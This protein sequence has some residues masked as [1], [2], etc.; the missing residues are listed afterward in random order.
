[1][2]TNIQTQ[3]DIVKLLHLDSYNFQGDG[4]FSR[5]NMLN[6]NTVLSISQERLDAGKFKNLKH[7]LGFPFSVQIFCFIL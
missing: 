3:T 6:K 2:L 4:S 7:S 1:M 5:V